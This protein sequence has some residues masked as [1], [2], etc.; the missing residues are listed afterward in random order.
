MTENTAEAP[1]EQEIV[2]QDDIHEMM[3]TKFVGLI[4]ER[5]SFVG[6]ANA[7]NGDALA[8]KEQITEESTDSDIVAARNARDEAI[9]ALEALVKPQVESMVNNA[10]EGLAE[11]EAS[12]KSIDEKLK[13]GLRFFKSV[14]GDD[15]FDKLPKQVR[16]KGMR[17]SNTGTS[18]KRIRGF[19]VKT[20]IDGD[21]TEFETFSQAA[22]YLDEDTSALQNAFF[23][24]AGT[25][26]LKDAPNEVSFNVTFTEVDEDGIESKKDASIFAYR[27][28]PDEDVAQSNTQQADAN[29][30]PN[31]GTPQNE[32][33]EVAYD[34]EDPQ[35]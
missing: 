34:D 21:I 13:P 3:H 28:E 6:R 1:V 26:T 12:I 4:K 33:D 23:S 9:E 32:Q 7:A 18:G 25:D 11:T 24:A 30:E 8:L 16:P 5:N 2:F 27:T 15:A 35:F 31:G 10:S 14:Y 17:L 29:E 22:K 20:T 19:N